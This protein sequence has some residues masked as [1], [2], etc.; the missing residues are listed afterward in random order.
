MSKIPIIIDTDVFGDPDDILAITYLLANQDKIEIKLIVTADEHKGM[1][2]AWLQKIFSKAG[3]DV[4]IVAGVDLGNTRLFLFDEINTSNVNFNYLEAIKEVIESNDSTT[5]LC[6]APQSNLAAF[7]SKY[8]HLKN[9]IVVKG[10]GAVLDIDLGRIEH[11]VK[12]D[13]EAFK[14]VASQMKPQLLL[15][16]H[17][18]HDSMQ[19]HKETEMYKMIDKST[20]PLALA[21]IKNANAFYDTLYPQSRFHDPILASILLDDFLEFTPDKL[22]VEPNGFTRRPKK[23][24]KGCEVT[25]S[26]SVDYD[27]LYTH[28]FNSLKQYL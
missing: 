23:G 20:N 13:I 25:V 3:L 11:N 8:P 16:D 14:T 4:P 22:I 28:F 6:M 1:R 7:I 21:I 5:Y 2:A 9:K 18:W 15:A 26:K 27:N 10:M 12:Y 17:T 19:F 24:E